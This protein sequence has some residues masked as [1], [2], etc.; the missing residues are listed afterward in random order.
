VGNPHLCCQ[1]GTINDM[2]FHL[3]RCLGTWPTGLRL[4]P[5]AQF[6]SCI[7]VNPTQEIVS[8]WTNPALALKTFAGESEA[9]W[10]AYTSKAVFSCDPLACWGK[11]QPKRPIRFME[12]GSCKQSVILTK[13]A[14]SYSYGAVTP[15]RYLSNG[16]KPTIS[17]WHSKHDL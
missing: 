4:H 7:Y 6:N 8:R 9:Y 13:T 3:G 1:R 15:H 17:L 16:C 2:L 10:T 14:T 12:Y 11:S 5:D